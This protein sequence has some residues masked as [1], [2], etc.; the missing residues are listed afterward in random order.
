MYD[1]TGVNHRKRIFDE[2]HG[3]DYRG[4]RGR[5]ATESAI[6]ARFFW[7]NWMSDVKNML[8]AC[9][10]CQVSKIDRNSVAGVIHS[11]RPSLSLNPPQHHHR[12]E[13]VIE[14]APPHPL[15]RTDIG[16]D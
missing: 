13:S 6:R 1:E 16:H 14:F 3:T 7:P 9:E 2:A 10:K 8:R 11:F 4:H 15:Y 5:V 12:R